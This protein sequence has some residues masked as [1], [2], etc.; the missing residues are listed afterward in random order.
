M[1]SETRAAGDA[2]ED[3][4]TSDSSTSE[5]VEVIFEDSSEVAVGRVGQ[6]ILDIACANDV[7]LEHNCGGVCACTTCHVVIDEGE[8]LL[9]EI[10]DDEEDRLDTA[11]GLTLH[12]R[13]GCQARVLRGGTIRL[14][15]P[16]TARARA[17][18][19]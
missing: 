11:D 12:S 8:E 16:P 6:S 7:D 2:V 14:H 5:A 15:I 1:T 19:H 10:E 3:T 18:P 9:S 13:L 4:A 17:T